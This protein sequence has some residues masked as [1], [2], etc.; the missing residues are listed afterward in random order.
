MSELEDM[1]CRARQACTKLGRVITRL[2][3]VTHTVRASP[4]IDAIKAALSDI[5][6]VYGLLSYYDDPVDLLDELADL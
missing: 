4:E 2:R 6:D 5:E 1:E 3:K